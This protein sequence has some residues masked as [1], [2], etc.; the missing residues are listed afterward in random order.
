MGIRRMSL[1]NKMLQDLDARGSQPGSAAVSAEIKPVP[2]PE[3]V[4]PWLRLALLGG[5]VAVLGGS[6][7][8]AWRITSNPAPEGAAAAE[9][10]VD[11][12]GG[13]APAAAPVPA[14]VPA[15]PAAGAPASP[16]PAPALSEEAAAPPAAPARPP[17]QTPP[18]VPNAGAALAENAGTD[19]TRRD[20]PAG[21]AAR[22][23]PADAAPERAAASPASKKA[24]PTDGGDEAPA[25]QTARTDA[26]AG[27]PAARPAARPAATPDAKA[28]D[29][30]SETTAQRAEN[31]YRRA[32]L[33]LEDGRVTEATGHLEEALRAE[34]RHE[35]A[36]Q[37]LVS[38][39]VEGKRT[40]EAIQQLATALALDPA[41]PA[42]AM[43][44]ARLQLERGESGIDTLM[45]TLPHAAGSADYRAFLAGALQRE[46]R[47]REAIEHYMAALR[48]A[49]RNGVWWMGLGMS[50]QAEKREPEAAAAFQRA[51]DSASLSADLRGFV[52]RKL[53]GLAR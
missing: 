14:P 20:R 52:E 19:P 45:R 51:L 48:I 31:A 6:G 36:R 34:P 53:K 12:S 43:L 18:L 16:A 22:A 42:M 47:H 23:R 8:M 38:L 40:E 13:Q 24:Q 27:V 28:P 39:L 17:V 15:A 2:P 32:L 50:L 11:I 44:L 9:V 30:R 49:P 7:Y 5:L 41:Q 4:V 29:G 46:G 25:R 35:A 33:S 37:T 3:R 21:A 26:A 1:I 10:P